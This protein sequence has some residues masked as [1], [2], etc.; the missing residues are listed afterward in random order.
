[1]HVRTNIEHNIIQVVV[2]SLCPLM[3]VM[4]NIHQ[5]IYFVVTTLACY[6]VSAFVCFVFKRYLSRNL[7]IFITALLSTFIVTIVTKY[8]GNNSFFKLQ[9][10]ESCYFAV[11]SA[12]CLC[13]DIYFIEKNV[14]VKKY[15]PKVL[16]DSLLFALIAFIYV[17]VI[18]L[19]GFGTAFGAKT[20]IGANSFFASI[21]FKLIWLG[22][23]AIF[24]DAIYRV[25]LRR[26]EQKTLAYQ[27]YVK[28][29]RDE[30]EFQYEELRRNKLLTSEIEIKKYGGEKPADEEGEKELP[31]E[32]DEKSET[33]GDE[34]AE[35]DEKPIKRKKKSKHSRPRKKG[36][37]KVEKVF[38]NSS[39]TD[40][41]GKE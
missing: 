35:S 32:D 2:L 28:K 3:L 22:V 21:T 40:E 30:K 4:E 39:K 29:I 11:L 10:E 13:I 1:M 6:W 8:L 15:L 34:T 14:V 26:A 7:K 16:T 24:S 36:K 17:F 33:E 37:G 25:C 38:K 5:A 18:E 27:K 23:V 20:L 12:T 9:S 19:F 41:G 31:Q